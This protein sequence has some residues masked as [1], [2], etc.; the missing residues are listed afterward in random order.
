MR[1][2]ETNKGR[3]LKPFDEQK[4]IFVHITKCAGVSIS[5]S[6]FGNQ[7][8]GHLRIPHYQLI[9]SQ[10]E[11]DRYYKFTFVRNPWDRLVSAFLFLK[12]GGT[13]KADRQWAQANLSQFEDFDSFVTGWVNRRNINRWKHFV[14]QYKFVCQPGSQTPNV[15]FIGYFEYLHEDFAQIQRKLDRHTSLEHLNKTEGANRDYRD[16]YTEA[17][18]KLVAEV[19]REDVNLF[20]YDFENASLKRYA[21][22]LTG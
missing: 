11:F 16:Y 18:R 4:C 6:L 12:K 2:I 22:A 9:F 14:P 7:G 1:N 19:Y 20:G 13:N 3:S 5:M 10:S 8:G 21:Y 15:D 17:T